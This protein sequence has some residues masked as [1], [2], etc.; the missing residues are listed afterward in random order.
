MSTII[1]DNKTILVAGAGGR[2]GKEI[3]AALLKAGAKVV[4][5]DYD[6]QAL[7]LLIKAHSFSPWLTTQRVD[8]TDPDSIRNAFNHAVTEF[9][10][11]DGAINTAYPRSKNYGHHFFDVTFDDFNANLTDHLGGFFVFMQQCAKYA[12]EQDTEFTLVNLSS[13]YGVIAPK[14][15]VYQDTEMTMPVEYAAIKSALQH[16]TSYVTAYTKGSHFRANC[17]SPGGIEAGQNQQ[18]IEQYKALCNSK[19]MLNSE[20]IVGTVLFLCSDASRYVKGQN[21]VVDDGFSI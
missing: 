12:I 11:L 4:A 10:R 13:I 1:L 19:G 9:G 7:E 2:L 16:I 18:F 3:V 8:I 5:T 17:V 6:A 21:I 15:S 14:F 20:D